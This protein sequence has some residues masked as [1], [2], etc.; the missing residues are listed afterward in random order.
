MPQKGTG[1]GHLGARDDQTIRI[2]RFFD[3]MRLSRSLRPMRLLRPLR[4]SESSRN[5]DSALFLCFEKKF[6]G[7]KS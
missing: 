5:L 1:I 7:L 6:F 4:A 2:S 3:E